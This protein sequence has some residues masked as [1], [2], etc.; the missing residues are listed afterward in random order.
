MRNFIF[1]ARPHQWIK[2]LVIFLPLVFTGNLFNIPILIDGVITFLS[3]S[4]VAI[5]IYFFNDVLDCDQDQQHPRKKY[6]PIASGKISK[7]FALSCSFILILLGLLTGGSVKAS[8]G[9]ILLIYVFVN[10]FYATVI[11]KILYLDVMAIALGFILRV[12]A[13][14]EL[15]GFQTS[16]WI[17]STT[18][19]LSL[20]LGFGKRRGELASLGENSNNHRKVLE[21]YTLELLDQIVTILA[22]CVIMSY[23]LYT[24]SDYTVQ[25]LGSNLFWTIP[26]VIYGV[27]RFF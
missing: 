16:P 3:F 7:S 26:F 5:A 17:L 8:V 20:M 21:Q 25:R 6:R 2:N 18:Y 23:I 10:I 27:F 4:L 11:K 19:L 13:G 9:I 12:Y 22:G 1:S 14:T 24:F 15:T